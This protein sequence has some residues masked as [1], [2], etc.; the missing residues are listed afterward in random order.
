MQQILP[1]VDFL[2]KFKHYRSLCK[3]KFSHQ[4]ALGFGPKFH[5]VI[6]AKPTY[7]DDFIPAQQQWT[8]FPPVDGNFMVDE[9]FLQLLAA[10]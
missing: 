10:V 4:D 6:D 7:P 5:T 2:C 9:K 8:A 1:V 3:Q